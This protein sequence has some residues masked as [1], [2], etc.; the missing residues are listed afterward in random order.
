MPTC[1]PAYIPKRETWNAC[2][3]PL[4]II[5]FGTVISWFRHFLT[6]DSCFLLPSLL[7]ASSALPPPSS[8][9]ACPLSSLHRVP[10][11]KS[12]TAVALRTAVAG[13]ARGVAAVEAGAKPVPSGE[14]S[15]REASEA[16]TPVGGRGSPSAK[17]KT[18]P[19]VSSKKQTIKSPSAAKQLASPSTNSAK[20]STSSAQADLEA[21]GAPGAS[22]AG[23]PS[24]PTKPPD[25]TSSGSVPG[26]VSYTRLTLPTI[27]LV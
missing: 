13:G 10:A 25:G 27:R 15:S 6:S 24:T 2:L 1:L 26:P 23:N 20:Q 9:P 12:T 19:Q 4:T 22:K 11:A 5:V 16:S 7:R 14:G 18:P 21:E 3:L 17:A 8:P